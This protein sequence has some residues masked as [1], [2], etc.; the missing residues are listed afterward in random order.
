MPPHDDDNLT[1]TMLQLVALSKALQA[2]QDQYQAHTQQATAAFEQEVKRTLGQAQKQLAELNRQALSEAMPAFEKRLSANIQQL[3][4]AEERLNTLHQSTLRQVKITT[5][6]TAFILLVV[7]GGALTLTGVWTK[8]RLQ[9]IEALRIY[10]ERLKLG[11]QFN[12]SSCGGIVCVK[13]DTQSPRWGKN[14]EYVL[15]DSGNRTT[16]GK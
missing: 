13:V 16:K 11:E 15:L 14:G 1:D 4:Q 6:F 7:C 10:E 5:I 12:L 2:Q 8:E 3:V 9:Q